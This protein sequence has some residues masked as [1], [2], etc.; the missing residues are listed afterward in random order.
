MTL[1][2][3][4]FYDAATLP[5]ADSDL[6]V[7][8]FTTGWAGMDVLLATIDGKHTEFP[9]FADGLS[10]YLPDAPQDHPLHRVETVLSGQFDRMSRLGLL[11]FQVGQIVHWETPRQAQQWERKYIR[12]IMDREPPLPQDKPNKSWNNEDY[13]ALYAE[14]REESAARLETEVKTLAGAIAVQ[15][16]AE[17]LYV[18]RENGLVAGTGWFGPLLGLA[19]DTNV[20]DDYNRQPHDVVAVVRQTDGSEALM[21]GAGASVYTVAT[22]AS[23]L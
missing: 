22:R 8:F 9:H 21:R 18:Q 14:I 16:E 20:E 6:L 3:P 2:S 15:N 10:G 7:P 1:V 11:T 5:N 13:A 19:I 23:I 17:H 12:E 4:G